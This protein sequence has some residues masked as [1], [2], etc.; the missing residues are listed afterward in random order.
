MAMRAQQIQDQ[1]RV[2]VRTRFGTLPVNKENLLDLPEGIPG[3]EGLHQFVLLNE[4]G[5]TSVF[6]L[7]SLDDPDIRLPVTS[8][9]WFRV[10]YQIELSDEELETLQLEHPDDTAILVT[11]ADDDSSPAGLRANFRGPIILNTEKRI[12]MQ[13]P[14]YDAQGSLVI[15]SH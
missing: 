14:M 4:E 1:G 10:D 13:K 7:Q 2:E 8:P 3:F 9:H 6:Y 15:R 12:G 5:N 11:I